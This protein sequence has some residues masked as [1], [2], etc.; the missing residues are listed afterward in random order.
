MSLSIFDAARDAPRE[1]A[2]ITP[3]RSFTFGELAD[4]AARVETPS[5]PAVIALSAPRGTIASAP[6]RSAAS[7]PSTVSARSRVTSVRRS[8]G[9]SED[10]QERAP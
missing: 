4:L 7:V 10:E 6:C 3:E 8:S 5:G 2:L 9:Y 1:P